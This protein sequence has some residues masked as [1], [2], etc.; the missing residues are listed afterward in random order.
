M[1]VGRFIAALI[2]TASVSV[3]VAPAQESGSQDRALIHAV[4]ESNL[5]AIKNAIQAGANVD[6]ADTSGATA[7]MQA[8]IYSD[9]ADTLRAAA[10]QLRAGQLP[11]GGWAQVRG[12]PGD[13]YATGQTLYALI[14][15]AGIRSNDPVYLKGVSFLRRTQLEDGSWHVR[16][17]S[18][19]LQPYFES[20]SPW[21]RPMDLR[22]R[23]RLG[24]RGSHFGPGRIFCIALRGPDTVRTEG[25]LP[26]HHPYI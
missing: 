6:A 1:K 13:A 2:A 15:A 14:Q 7:L 8:A 11:N 24:C 23:F 9:V 25:T 19:K 10:S 21:G 16:S 20:G 12:L 26:N 3:L 22:R 18:V 4:Q 17:R 5:G